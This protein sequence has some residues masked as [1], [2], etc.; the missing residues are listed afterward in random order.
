[1]EQE[2][3]KNIETKGTGFGIASLVL[4]IISIIFLY[5]IIISIISAI[6]AVIFGIVAIKRG[7]RT[8]GKNRSSIRNS[9]INNYFII[10]LIFK[11]IRCINFHDTRLV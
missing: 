4:G 9:F 1:M 10:I 8:F 7:D 2:T 6:L 11:S 5:Y 3:Q